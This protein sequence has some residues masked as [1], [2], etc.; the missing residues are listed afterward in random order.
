[1]RILA[2]TNMY[3]TKE[4]PTSGSFIE[5]QVKGLREIGLEVRTML[6]NR[7]R[8]GRGVYLNVPGQ[9]RTEVESFDPDLVHVMYG[10][11]MAAQVSRCNIRPM[12]VTFHGSDL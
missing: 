8:D 4:T 12:I 10:G 11:F 1:M 9:L 3:P 7:V 6:V 2:V 5:Q